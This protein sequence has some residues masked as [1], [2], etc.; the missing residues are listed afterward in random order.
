VSLGQVGA[1]G[2]DGFGF[3]LGWQ[4]SQALENVE[5]KRREKIKMV[6]M[7]FMEAMAIARVLASTALNIK[8]LVGF[9]GRLASFKG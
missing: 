3:G 1:V 6:A 2:G 7:N 8:C 4:G 9:W 5:R